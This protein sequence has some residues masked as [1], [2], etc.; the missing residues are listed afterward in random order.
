MPL[1]SP[2]RPPVHL[3]NMT[4]IARLCPQCGAPTQGA[5]CPA[6]GAATF[7]L[8]PTVDAA[9]LAPAVVVA[10]AYR[11]VRTLGR[12]G[13]GAVYEADHPAQHGK[14]A[15]TVLSHNDLRPEQLQ[16]FYGDTHAATQLQ[17]AHLAR[18]FE[19]GQFESGAWFVA[20]ELLEGASL[21]DLLAAASQQGRVLDQATAIAVG[22]GVLLGLAEAHARGLVHRD[23]KPAHVIVSETQGQRLVKVV[24]FGVAHLHGHAASAAGQASGPPACLSPEQCTGDPVDARADLYALGA[25]LYR[26]VCGRAPFVDPNPQTVRFAHAS[27]EPPELLALAKTPVSEHFAMTVMRALA[28]AP[29]GRFATARD[30]HLALE[31]ARA[32]PLFQPVGGVADAGHLVAGRPLTPGALVAVD[33]RPSTPSVPAIADA[34]QGSAAGLA[35]AAAPSP[36]LAEDGRSLSSTFKKP[37]FSVSAP[38]IAAVPVAVSAPAAPP[39]AAATAPV[40]PKSPGSRRLRWLVLG[41][42]GA[43]AA[44]AAVAWA[45]WR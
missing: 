9:T 24:G 2:R 7:A 1:F 3:R 34:Q 22:C 33:R 40:A 19:V 44:A 12:S 41:G 10:G 32:A 26:C 39:T 18:V 30:M 16:S 4:A 27:Q 17:H 28:K 23:L 14:V 29:A 15:L 42:V 5:R 31:A 36:A 43:L 25:I 13:A 37:S 20:S 6:D 35:Q 45:G 21:E 11:I 8:Q 38:K